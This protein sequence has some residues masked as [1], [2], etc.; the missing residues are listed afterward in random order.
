MLGK[1]EGK[2][3]R[4]WEWVRWHHRIRGHESQQTPGDS[5]GRGSLAS[6][7]P[8]GHK[9]SDTTEQMNSSSSK[10]SAWLMASRVPTRRDHRGSKLFT[11]RRCLSTAQTLSTYTRPTSQQWK[12]NLVF[13]SQP[14][15][16]ITAPFLCRLSVQGHRLSSTRWY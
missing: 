12:V 5:E 10:G 3:G 16:S 9:E 4:R 13:I 6:C 2:R 14:L 15:E 11:F 7:G 1:T 8:R